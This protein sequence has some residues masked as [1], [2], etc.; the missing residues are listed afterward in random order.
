MLIIVQIIRQVQGNV[1]TAGKDKDVVGH[2]N[3][4]TNP[5][6]NSLF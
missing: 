1:N 4:F 2:Q 5:A 6:L 3:R